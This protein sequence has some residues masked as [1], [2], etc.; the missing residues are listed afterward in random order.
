MPKIYFC[1]ENWTLDSIPMQF[2]DFPFS[3]PKLLGSSWSNS[4]SILKF[5]HKIS[6]FVLLVVKGTVIKYYIQYCTYFF[7]LV[8]PCFHFFKRWW[9]WWW[10]WIVF[11]V[12]L[13][14]ERRLALFPAVTIVKDPYHCESPT[15]CEQDFN[16]R[17]TWVK[18]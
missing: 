1:R 11:V 15:R 3:S 12:W 8:F 18:A 4:Y 16:L 9:W 10:W 2:W 14:N 13:T 6:N 17:R 5:L 7:L